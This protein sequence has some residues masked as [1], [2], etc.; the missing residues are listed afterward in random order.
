MALMGRIRQFNE[1]FD[2]VNIVVKIQ[3]VTEHEVKRHDRCCGCQQRDDRL[4][5][6]SHIS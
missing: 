1:P 3:M 2:H 4:Y 5:D 6:V